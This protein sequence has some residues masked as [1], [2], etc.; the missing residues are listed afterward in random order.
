[1]KKKK[2]YA[3]WANLKSEMLV[4]IL[5]LLFC[6]FFLLLLNCLHYKRK[7]NLSRQHENQN[8]DLDDVK[9]LAFISL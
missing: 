4:L 1:M 9:I 5:K 7:K 3:T 6:L 8:A 2:L